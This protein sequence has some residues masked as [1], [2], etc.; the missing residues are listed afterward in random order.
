MTDHTLAFSLQLGKRHDFVN[1]AD[2]MR[3]GNGETLAGERIATHLAHAN[4]VVELRD[5][6]GAGN[7]N[8]DLSNRKVR[9]VRGNHDITS[10]DKS[11]T[12][13]ETDALYQCN[14]RD[15]KHIEPLNRLG[16]HAR[17]AQIV[18]RRKAS[19]PVEPIDV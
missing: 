12:A 14:G 16:G 17:S 8:A 4:G 1:E 11:S 10:R 2:A 6:N 3:F 19:D 5:N 13:T 15:R 7:S 18:L 9:V